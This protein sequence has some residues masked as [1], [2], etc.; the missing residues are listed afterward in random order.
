MVL[1][2]FSLLFAVEVGPGHIHVHVEIT[3][4]DPLFTILKYSQITQIHECV[5]LRIV[6]SGDASPFKG[7]R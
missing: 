4:V 1:Q 6:W 2:S 7:P 5:R 3:C